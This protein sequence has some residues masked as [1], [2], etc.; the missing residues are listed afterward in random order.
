MILRFLRSARATVA[1]VAAAL[2]LSAC[3]FSPYALPLPG[4]ADTGEHPYTVKVEFRDVLDLVPQ[5]GVRVDDVAVGRVTDIEL[6]GWHAEVTLKINGKAD[7]PANSTARIRQTSLLG[8]KFVSLEP[9]E[10]GAHGSLKDGDVIPLDRSGRNPEVE[11]VLGAASL[12]FNGGGLD[13][14]ST[15]VREV[16]H[17]LDGN[18][19]DVKELIRNSEQLISRLDSHKGQILNALEKINNVAIQ[20]DKQSDAITTA[21]DTMPEALDVLNDQRDEL[22]T[23]LN[24]LD[25]FGQVGSRVI[26]RSK[27]DLLANLQALQPVLANLNEAGDSLVQSLRTLP[28]FP[29]SDEVVGGSYAAASSVCPPEKRDD[30][31]SKDACMGDY[32]NLYVQLNLSAESLKD[33]ILNLGKS[34]GNALGDPGSTG[35]PGMDKLGEVPGLDKLPDLVGGLAQQDADES[36]DTPAAPSKQPD[37]SS[38]EQP[39][40]SES[41]KLCSVLQL[42]RPAAGDVIDSH[43]SLRE[44]MLQTVVEP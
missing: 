39:P 41:P 26:R 43:D 42:C 10:D 5:S 4:G 32:K 7:V 33:T 30:P 9:P 11:E 6:S 3:E 22:V 19:G 2:L 36:D 25:E 14:V 23:L 15:I 17:A 12:L 40:G 20:A 37:D 27:A 44:L 31:T 8:E 28:S 21:L 29:F 18:E 34:V 38:D 16:N 1:L 35:L 24:S 13:K